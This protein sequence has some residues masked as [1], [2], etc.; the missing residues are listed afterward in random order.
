MRSFCEW[1]SQ[2]SNPLH[3]F[4]GEKGTG[5]R[6]VKGNN[7]DPPSPFD[8]TTFHMFRHGLLIVGSRCPNR[9]G[10]WNRQSAILT[11]MQQNAELI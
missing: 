3:Q 9:G 1:S 7:D 2:E 4:G 5:A 11:A 6:R 8:F 10:I